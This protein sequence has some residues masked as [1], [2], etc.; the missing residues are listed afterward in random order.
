M[1]QNLVNCGKDEP[2]QLLGE[3]VEKSVNVNWN[4]EVG[5][6]NRDPNLVKSGEGEPAQPVESADGL[7]TNMDSNGHLPNGKECVSFPPTNIVFH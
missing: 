4:G 1:D 5:V 6:A 3:S 2:A 7:S